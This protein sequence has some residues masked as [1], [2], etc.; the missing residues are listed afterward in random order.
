M[1]PRL[2]YTVALLVW[3]LNQGWAMHKDVGEWKR[4]FGGLPPIKEWDDPNGAR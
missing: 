1:P 4:T 3:S 2:R